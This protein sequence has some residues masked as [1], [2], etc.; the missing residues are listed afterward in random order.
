MTRNKKIVFVN[1]YRDREKGRKALGNVARCTGQTPVLVE[2][3][4]PNLAELVTTLEPSLMLLS[5]SEFLLSKPRTK[6]RFRQEMELV[7]KAEFPVLGICFGHQLIGTA[8]GTGMS[9]LGQMV[10]RFENVNVLDH[11]P[12]FENLPTTISVAA[13]HRQV[14]DRVPEGFARLAQSATSDIEAIGHMS[15][16]IFGLQFHPERADDAHPHGQILLRNMVQLSDSA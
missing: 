1:N 4:A 10:R 5:G 7:R 12:L 16:P 13:S 3:D 15:L 2:Y 8:F 11:N 14:L 9:D 6:E